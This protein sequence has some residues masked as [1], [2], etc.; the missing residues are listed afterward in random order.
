MFMF[1]GLLAVGLPTHVYAQQSS[2]S[3]YS[4]DEAF[5][6]TGGELEASSTNY[7]AK[8]GTGDTAAGPTSST[9]FSTVLGSQ[10]S[11]EPI[12][13]FIVSGAD[14][15]HGVLNP[16][17]TATGTTDIWVRT[18]NSSGYVMQ[19][20]GTPPGQSVHTLPGLTMPTASHT[21]E[22]QFG[23]NLRDNTT[24]NIG[25]DPVQVPDE[26]F[27]YGIPTA[28]YNTP[29]LYKYVP[30][31]IIAV[32]ESATGETHFMMSY[33]MNVSNLTPAGRYATT[34]SIVVSAN[35]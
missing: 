16:S 25:A 32:S 30:G 13:E 3:N 5:F 10:T 22:E 2:S 18:Y 19:T 26:T 24:P 33:I 11:T 31:D 6:G 27:S 15:D 28:D 1:V 23:I 12:L 21:N 34:I 9:S 20:A 35:F 7:K 8:Q 14:N 17:V 4:V 29:D